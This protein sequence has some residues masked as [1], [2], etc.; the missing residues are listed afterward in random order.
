MD[1][2]CTNYV[3]SIKYIIV[4]LIKKQTNKTKTH[5]YPNERE[6]LKVSVGQ[7]VRN[8]STLTKEMCQTCCKELSTANVIY[9]AASTTTN[10]DFQS[11]FFPT[12]YDVAIWQHTPKYP[13][14]FE[15]KMNKET[16]YVCV[17]LSHLK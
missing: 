12:W 14:K 17:V 1:F 9:T 8:K 13:I 11:A 4:P 2:S 6:G 5:S 3:L 16:F 10:K 15:T 7:V